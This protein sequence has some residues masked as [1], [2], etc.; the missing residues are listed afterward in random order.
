MKTTE[1]TI[2]RVPGPI[3]YYDERGEV[4]REVALLQEILSVLKRI[5]AALP[6]SD[7]PK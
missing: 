2:T 7:K 1:E 5:E 6:A 4:T 3:R